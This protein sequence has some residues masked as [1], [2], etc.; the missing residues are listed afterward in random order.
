MILAKEV[1]SMSKAIGVLWIL[2]TLSVVGSVQLLDF[3]PAETDLL[4][5]YVPINFLLLYL[6]GRYARKEA[7]IG[8]GKTSE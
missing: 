4:L 5:S 8:M 7:K 1:V 6:G 3:G 2:L